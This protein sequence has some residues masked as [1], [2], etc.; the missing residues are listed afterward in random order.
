MY[1]P[2]R[3]LRITSDTNAALPAQAHVHGMTIINGT[4]SAAASLKAHDAATVTGNPVLEI[5]SET[6]TAT[7]WRTQTDIMLPVPLSFLLGV[8]LDIAG[9]SAVGYVY[10]SL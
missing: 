3:S 4:T 5:N 10:Y 7:L 1:G 9:T 6:V 8:S 2:L